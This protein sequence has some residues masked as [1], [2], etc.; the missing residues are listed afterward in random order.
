MGIEQAAGQLLLTSVV[1]SREPTTESREVLEHVPIGGL[2]LFSYNL[3][4]GPAGV[5]GL[6]AKVQEIALSRPPNLPYLIAIDHEGGRVQRLKR[7]FTRL[8]SPRIMGGLGI[9]ALKRLARAAA[10]QLSAVGVNMN[11]APV[12]EASIGAGDVI[13]DRSFSPEIDKA[14]L[15]AGAFITGMQSRGIIATAKHF[16]GNAV[17]STDPHKDMPIISL[18]ADEIAR[19]LL[20]PF[21][22]AIDSG[23]DAIMLSHAIV[24]SLDREHPIALSPKVVNGLLRKKLGFEGL[25]CSDDLMMGAMVKRFEP[26]RAAVLAIGAGV[27]LL[28]LSNP[29]KVEEVYQ[30]I[31]RAVRNGVLDERLVRNACN[32]VVGVKKKHGLRA[33]VDKL[34]RGESLKRLGPARKRAAKILEEFI[35]QSKE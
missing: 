16:P 25:I 28:M 24:P 19:E 7:G 4:G 32:R 22:A 15:L 34:I 29:F 5:T 18:S 13:S 3:R 30:G 20:P 10:D 27:D 1:G 21:K 31:L 12:V 33:K 6:V 14:A 11:L 2:V 23:V 9:D 26:A 8:P 17:S 35:P